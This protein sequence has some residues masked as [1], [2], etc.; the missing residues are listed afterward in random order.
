MS[1]QI[2]H[3]KYLS[4]CIAFP[5]CQ[6]PT[7]NGAIFGQSCL[8]Y[9]FADLGLTKLFIVDGLNSKSIIYEGTKASLSKHIKLC[10][11]LISF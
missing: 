7:L 2:L 8:F 6:T 9:S 4:H 1:P 5:L 11:T 3:S 10:I